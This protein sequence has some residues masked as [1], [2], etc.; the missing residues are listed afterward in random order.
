MADVKKVK[1]GKVIGY[2]LYKKIQEKL[3]VINLVNFIINLL[4]INI[5]II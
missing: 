4:K 1:D 2:T 3:I 5:K